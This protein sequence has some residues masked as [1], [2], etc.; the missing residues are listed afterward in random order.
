MCTITGC[1]EGRPLTRKILRTAS[2]LFAFAPR[3]YT[4]SVGNATSSPARSASTASWISCC[5]TRPIAMAAMIASGARTVRRARRTALFE[6]RPGPTLCGPAQFVSRPKPLVELQGH[7]FDRTVPGHRPQPE[8][9][10]IFAP[11]DR[12]DELIQIGDRFTIDLD[13]APT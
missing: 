9:T 8:R 6:R 12:L 5:R 1:V 11:A 2:G 3:P 13:D 10:A 7:D 4:V